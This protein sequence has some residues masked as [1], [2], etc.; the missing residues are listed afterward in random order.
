MAEMYCFYDEE[1]LR[2]GATVTLGKA[3]SQHLVKV[4][5]L[6][7]GSEVHVLDGQGRKARGIISSIATKMARVELLAVEMV[8]APPCA[9]HLAQVIPKGKCM[10]A[11]I[12]KAT[13]IGVRCIY[14]LLSDH[15]EVR[16]D[17]ERGRSKRAGWVVTA[18]EACKQCGCPYLPEIHPP[19]KVDE[20]FAKMGAFAPASSWL[21]IASLEE[22]AVYLGDY[23][24][25]L[26]PQPKEALW[27]IGPEGDFSPREYAQARAAGCLPVGLTQ[28][29]LRSETAATYALSI[30]DY[31]LHALF[32]RHS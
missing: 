24:A 31:E 22:D 23:R 6:R 32:K 20:F 13:E 28:N 8:A 9:M 5:R 2:E 19:Q 12:R 17:A 30:L 29:V 11:I 14:P 4:L 16:L 25:T 3:E 1:T 10:D 15:S 21:L 26:P 7:P 18:R 27:L